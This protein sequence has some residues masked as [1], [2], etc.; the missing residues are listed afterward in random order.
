MSQR[1]IIFH[2]DMNSFYASVEMSYNPKL[3]GKPI[4]IA[5]N[6]EERRGIIVTSSYEAR[7]KG[8]KTAMPI[9]Q[10]KQLCPKLLILPPNFERYRGASR[11]IFSLLQEYTPLVQPVSIDEG[12]LDVTSYLAKM[13]P[14]TL[15]QDIQKRILEEIDLP[16][17]IGIA[18]NKF[19]AKMA[20]DMKKPNGITILR[21]RDVE[22]KLWP[23]P[24]DEMYG[25]GK[26]TVDKWRKYGYDT[27]GD[28][29]KESQGIIQQRF[30]MNGLK[31]H[32]RSNGVD[33]R[34]VDP[35][36]FYEFKSVGHSTT[37]REDT[38]SEQKISATF[39]ALANKVAERL[40]KKKVCANGV[41]ITIR[42]HNWKTVTKSQKTLNP[43]QYSEDIFKEAIHLW[44]TAWN[45][46]DVRL[47][48]ISTYDLVEQR[49]AY[50]QLDLFTYKQDAKTDD[51]LKTIETI[52]SKYGEKSLFKGNQIS[53]ESNDGL[54]NKIGEGTSLE[55]DFLDE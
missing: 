6:V 24:I 35:Q 18:P 12:Y 47:L 16:C 5:G 2:V 19:L 44:R 3:K 43:L 21:K 39:Q 52:R 48:G 14:V 28:L 25:I 22:K 7:A 31:L 17:S 13:H 41:Q 20:S 40:S 49:Y 34:P 26:R 9:W 45:G 8:V 27:I 46:D 37:L 36:A 30:G 1:R 42:Y 4:A 23:L 50:K 33:K 15:A 38:R 51:L 32:E 29:A 11:T 53:L 10:A 54:S 55:R